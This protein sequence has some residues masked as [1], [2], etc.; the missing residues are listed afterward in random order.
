MKIDR[1][2][3]VLLGVLGA[4]FVVLVWTRLANRP[5]RSADSD[6]AL[7][8][9]RPAP[10]A[11]LPAQ[12]RTSRSRRRPSPPP[13]TGVVEIQ[14]ASL[15]RSEGGE[16]RPGRNPFDFYTPPPPPPP[17]VVKPPPPPPVEVAQP[18]EVIPP[19]PQP[20]PIRLA[21]LGS[22]GPAGRRIAVFSDGENIYNA[23]IGDVLTGDFE[24]VEIGYESVQLKYVDFPDL[25]AAQ[26]RVGTEGS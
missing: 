24:L 8:G 6:P 26:L 5:P 22:F 10:A 7:T 20:P 2:Q 23:L 25:P 13:E 21:Y 18:R 11:A 15:A 4:L 17:P 16:Y 12:R 1:R 9:V 14:L 3:K 19:R